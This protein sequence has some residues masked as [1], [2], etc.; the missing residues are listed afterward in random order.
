MTGEHLIGQLMRQLPPSA[1][2]H[3]IGKMLE[4]VLYSKPQ[5][6]ICDEARELLLGLAGRYR[7]SLR[8]VDI[9]R[10]ETDFA[11]FRYRIPVF[12]IGAHEIAA[13]ITAGELEDA[14]ATAI[15]PGARSAEGQE[16]E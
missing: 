5:C 13:P 12:Q 10:D 8:E 4:I 3:I 1:G 16:Q 14:L 6:S 9:T 2:R 11:S 7:F 15:A